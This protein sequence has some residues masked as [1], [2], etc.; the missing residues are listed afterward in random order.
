MRGIILLC[1]LEAVF[2]DDSYNW[3]GPGHVA[4]VTHPNTDCSM[5]TGSCGCCLMQ[6]KLHRLKTY[7]N[8]TFDMLEKEYSQTKQSFDIIETSR[9]AFSVGLFSDD[10][11]KCYGPFDFDNLIAYKQVFLNLGGNYNVETGIFTVPCSGVYILAITVYSDAGAPGAKLS[12]CARLQVDDQVV[13]GTTDVN[14]Y[15][16]EDSATIV[17]AL[18][19]MVEEQVAVSLPKGCF[20]CD[21]NSHYNTFSAFLLYA[22]E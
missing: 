17:V 11:A 4:P 6:Q 1:L 18:Q 3:D 22:T 13:A 2:A 10:R 12:A 9:T 5:D 14:T 20:L 19:L 15:D 7:F 16:Q 21:N 8:E